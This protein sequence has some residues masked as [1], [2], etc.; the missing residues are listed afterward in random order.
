MRVRHTG[1]FGKRHN[2]LVDDDATVEAVRGLTKI[3][4]VDREGRTF[5]MFA[6]PVELADEV[7]GTIPVGRLKEINSI[8]AFRRLLG[9]IKP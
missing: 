5:W 9:A 8:A 4:I 3:Q 1:R 6:D 2:Q 7:L